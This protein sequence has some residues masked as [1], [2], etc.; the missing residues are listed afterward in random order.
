MADGY[1][2]F[3]S[4]VV[5]KMNDIIYSIIDCCRLLHGRG[6]WYVFFAIGGNIFDFC[7]FGAS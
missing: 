5:E 4:A 6:Y 3:L 2:Y 7:K 1:E